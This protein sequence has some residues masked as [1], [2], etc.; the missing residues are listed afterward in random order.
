M[1]LII[2]TL[3]FSNIILPKAD[4]N[5]DVVLDLFLACLDTLLMFIFV[6]AVVLWVSMS[7]QSVPLTILSAIAGGLMLPY[8]T[9]ALGIF[10]PNMPEGAV[11][12]LS[13]IPTYST[14]GGFASLIEIPED[15]ATFDPWPQIIGS[16][17]Y[18]GFGTLFILLGLH[19]FKRKDLK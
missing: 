11:Y 12:W 3:I 14:A 18:I 16:I 8:I 4:F 1:A 13:I 6:S 10:E 5:A 9:M 19:N 15:A 2:S 17:S 7:T